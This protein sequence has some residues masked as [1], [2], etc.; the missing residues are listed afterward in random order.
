MIKVGCNY[1]SLS[2][3]DIERFIQTAYE[4]RLD[5]VD[6]HRRAFAS[7][8]PDYLHHIKM[9][10]LK[11]GLPIGY[12]GVS[13]GFVGTTEALRE[14]V[15]RCKE[16]IDLAAFIGAPLIRVFGG[17]VPPEVEDREPLFQALTPCLREVADYGVEKGVI[18]ALQ[19]H[20]N[21]N[22][23][24]TS[25][26]VLRILR[27]TNHPNFSFIL[28]T[29]QW[30]GSVGAH[31][32]RESDPNVDIYQYIEQTVP[33]AIYVRTKFYKIESGREEWLDYER[34]LRILK[35][36]NYNGCLSIVYEG[37]EE[38]RV[39]AVRKAANHLRAL[40]SAY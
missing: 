32:R 12:L 27:E 30:E 7:T 15:A 29:G 4:L 35:G 38:D 11:H 24:A 34:I 8:K 22:I 16:A 33:Y 9:L 2:D 10:C 13:S 21:S 25:N 39:E 20:N 14:Q 26:D 3:M 23:A 17:H 36:V 40:L 6:F 1:L 5:T 31:P 18:V 28:D 19:N 37:Q